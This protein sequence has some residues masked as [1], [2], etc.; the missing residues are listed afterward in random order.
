[1]AVRCVWIGFLLA[2]TAF[3][4][5]DDNESRGERFLQLE[6]IA[7]GH[8]GKQE[9]NQAIA[10]FEQ[11]IAVHA[12][13]PRPYYNIACAY[14]LQGNAERAAIWLKLSIDH[15]WR[16]ASHLDQDGDWALVR[17]SDAYKRVRAALD[18]VVR[19]DPPPLPHS[20]DPATAPPAPSVVRILAGA[21]I[22]EQRLELDPLLMEESQ[23]RRRLFHFYDET[24]A[25]L[26]RYILENGDAPDAALA[27]RERVRIASLYRVRA[28]EKAAGDAKLRE[29]ADR[30][31]RISADEF[32]ERWPGSPYLPDVLL[33]RAAAE[34][35]DGAIAAFEQIQ[36]DFPG[37]EHAI[38][39][40]AES[41]MRRAGDD[42][43]E[44]RLA[45][46]SFDAAYGQTELGRQL[47]E[48]R[49]WRIR[50]QARGIR[51][52]PVQLFKPELPAADRGYLLLVIAIAGEPGSAEV[53]A[54]AR[55]RS[56][57]LKGAPVGVIV[58]PQQLSAAQRAWVAK[59]AHGL[60]I[61]SEPEP[62]AR[63]LQVQEA[64]VLLEFRNGELVAPKRN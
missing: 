42:R 47:L 41:L 56:A 57:A 32:V 15:G 39:A 51:D 24:M 13:N 48:G 45:Y 29:V 40:A 64:P 50:L 31:I 6:E 25:R 63:Y 18:E 8:F 23:I 52:L 1:M 33:W 5:A 10:T 60:H 22:D 37:T 30:Y 28:D 21:F 3:A 36:R 14:A 38:R 53:I 59:H 12:D 7:F 17:E 9:W 26:A 62:I 34:S 4:Q 27:G 54:G 61:A 46:L 11:Q 19:R 44:L 20:I 2:A 49:L 58:L 43:D 35:P 16:N 55:Q